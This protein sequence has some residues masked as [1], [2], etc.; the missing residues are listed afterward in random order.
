MTAALLFIASFALVFGLCIQQFN[1]QRHRRWAVLFTSLAVSA[2]A[3]VQF[4]YLPGPTGPLELLAFIFGN[5]AGAVLS[6]DGHA[7]LMHIAA[8]RRGARHV[9]PP[10]LDERMGQIGETLR[11]AIEI[12]H[13]ATVSDIERFCPSNV[14]GAAVWR[15]TLAA[16]T[17]PE[18]VETDDYARR[19][20][21]RAVEFLDRRGALIHHP[22]VHTLVRFKP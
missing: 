1:L 20:V 3:I 10:T 14:M 8:W 18:D 12:A 6:I 21:D 17:E 16:A 15:D 4:K 19:V 5:A 22:N 11:Q 9:E 13:E 2:A 7:L